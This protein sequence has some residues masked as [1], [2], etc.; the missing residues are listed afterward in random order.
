VTRYN[1]A[2]FGFLTIGQYDLTSVT[3][4]LED[5]I[6]KPAIESTPYGVTAPEYLSGVLK[7][8]E[9]TGQDGWYDDATNSVNDAMVALASGE[10]VMILAPW[11]NTVPAS[12]VGKTCICTDGVLST[13]YKRAETVGDYTKASF[14]VAV[15]GQVDQRAGLVSELAARDDAATTA[16]TYYNFGADGAAG[17]R[18]YLVITSITWDTQT[19]LLV[20]VQDCNTS[21][22]AY[23]DHTTFTSVAAPATGAAEMKVLD[24]AAIQQ[25]VCTTLT[26]AGGAG[27]HATY[28]VAVALD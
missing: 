13:A 6:S 24:H 14:E 27:G 11:G 5:S 22:G 9:L 2:E 17:G 23:A 4:K 10:R 15:S 3:N 19:S 26:F 1:S 8:Y 7:S 28:A 16:A 25:Y 12:G 18:M 21:G 20:A